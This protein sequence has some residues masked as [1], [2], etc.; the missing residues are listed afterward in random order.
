MAKST[1]IQDESLI[2]RFIIF[3]LGLLPGES[4]EGFDESASIEEMCEHILYYKEHG[5]DPLVDN[6]C[7]FVTEEVIKFGGLCRAFYSLQSTIDCQMN[8]NNGDPNIIR[9]SRTKEVYL[10][11]CSLIFIPLESIEIYGVV[12]VAQLRRAGHQ[13]FSQSKERTKGKELGLTTK[14]IR[15]KVQKAHDLFKLMNGG[16]IHRRL[17]NVD[18]SLHSIN[19][20]TPNNNI[21]HASPSYGG[22]I[23]LYKYLKAMRK[24][25]LRMDYE[26]LTHS[27]AETL[28]NE[29]QTLTCQLSE[30]LKLLPIDAL[31]LDLKQFYDS[32]LRDICFSEC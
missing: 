16:G 13:D 6:R 9:N 20:D 22:M 15:N 14:Q 11:T 27:E 26:I 23:Q 10:S 3:H 25:K 17:S 2:Q 19:S 28:R 32:F 8:I 5:N 21:S 1:E 29:I 18:V 24:M 31:R 12:A 30:F 7:R 4:S